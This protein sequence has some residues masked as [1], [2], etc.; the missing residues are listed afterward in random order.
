MQNSDCQINYFSMKQ[1]LILFFLHLSCIASYGQPLSEDR[2]VF[3]DKLTD[4]YLCSIDASYFD[5]EIENETFSDGKMVNFT[6]LPIIKISGEFSNDYSAGTVTL[7]MPD[8]S[9]QSLMPAKL[10]WRGG[11]TNKANRHKKNYHIKFLNED[12]E[13]MDRKFF[14]MRKDNSWLLDAAQIDMSRVRNRVA[15]ELWN[16]F[17]QKPYY[18]PEEPKMRNYTRGQF[19]ELFLDDEYR[20]IYCLSEAIDRSQLK[21]KKT[22]EE[23]VHGCL[24]KSSGFEFTNFR[25]YDFYDDSS[26]TWGSFEAKYPE[27][28][29]DSDTD[30]STLYDAV[31]FVAD[32]SYSDFYD[33]VG[34]FIDI[35]VYQD[36]FLFAQ[37]LN[38]L[39]NLSGKNMYW[40][41]YDKQID[42][43]ITLIPW[44]LDCTVGQYFE[45]TNHGYEELTRPEVYYDKILGDK[46]GYYLYK[47]R[48]DAEGNVYPTEWTFLNQLNDR[49]TECRN[50][51]FSED[52]LIARYDHYMDMLTKSGAYGRE[53]N[54]W[55]GDS[56][57]NGQTLDFEK[58]REYIHDWIH[59]RLLSLDYQFSDLLDT[60]K[61]YAGIEN[62]QIENNKKHTTHIYNISG[63]QVIG[64]LQNLPSGVYIIN[65]RKVIII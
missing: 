12:G 29:N 17:G 63:M 28:S 37:V 57:I 34:E 43:K 47:V 39:D 55:S 51:I 31:K 26:E 52:S 11:T 64:N 59:R 27:V 54:R 6:F 8:G 42:K 32:A 60:Y 7:A 15:M 9:V 36:Y 3:Y 58:E 21:L 30:W 38:A 41:C 50:D 2:M 61:E 20:G 24:W 14:D 16:D 4:S 46:I 62:P 23:G 19:V 40:A 25:T 5:E 65:G 18:F 33:N 10:K 22:D 56:D 35:P 1:F 44:D 53:S 45:N 49:Y 13:K 48:E